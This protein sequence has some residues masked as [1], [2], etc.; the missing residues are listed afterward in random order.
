V[1]FIIL[2]IRVGSFTLECDMTW[3]CVCYVGGIYYKPVS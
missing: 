3:K 2:G 1:N